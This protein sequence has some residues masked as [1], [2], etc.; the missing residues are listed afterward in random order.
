[1]KKLIAIL[2][3]AG[4]MSCNNGANDGDA[5]TDTTTMPPDTNLQNQT[6]DHI[7]RADGQVPLDSSRHPDSLRK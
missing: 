2:M 6:S 3:V 4:M 5:S 7:N 1:M